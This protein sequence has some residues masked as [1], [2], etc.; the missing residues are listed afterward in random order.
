MTVSL[1]I[2]STQVAKLMP[3]FT[4]HMI[5]SFVQFDDNFAFSALTVMKIVLKKIHLIVVTIA[6]VF[7]E[8]ALSAKYFSAFFAFWINPLLYLQHSFIAFFVW[9]EFQFW[10]L[11]GHL[12][13]SNFFISFLNVLGQSCEEK[14]I[15]VD[16]LIALF[17]GAYY[18]FKNACFIDN[19]VL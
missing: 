18:I 15:Y 13:Q 2:L 16:D 17:I 3:T 1:P 8:H 11:G 7:G 9:A 6:F 4:G 5:A 19:I 14:Q 12:K 10:V